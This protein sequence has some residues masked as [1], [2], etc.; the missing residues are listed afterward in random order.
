MADTSAAD[1]PSLTGK[2]RETRQRI[3]AAAADLVFERRR[4]GSEP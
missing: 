3:I 1:S 2:G 4:G